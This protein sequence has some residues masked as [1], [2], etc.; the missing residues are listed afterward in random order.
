MT[1]F[2]SRQRGSW[3]PP[4]EVRIGGCGTRRLMPTA[5]RAQ[6]QYFSE[7][8]PR[9]RADKPGS[10]KNEATNMT[11]HRN[12]TFTLSHA[13][14]GDCMHTGILSCASDATLA[15]VAEIMSTNR[16]HA[17]AVTDHR[18]TRPVGFISDLDVV[19][20]VTTGTDP[21]ASQAAATQPLAVSE[22][23][24]LER[25]AELMSEHA[26]THLIVLDAA[27]G[28]PVGVLSALD[29][30]AAYADAAG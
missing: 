15:D 3:T 11:N 29:I 18:S 10:R 5:T 17:V 30:A 21:S 28:Y 8:R 23:E 13:R 2:G 24:P 27:S 4:D 26:L 14:V 16:V 19:T 12:S 9:R 22:D 6:V 7:A 1:A 25:A 20:A